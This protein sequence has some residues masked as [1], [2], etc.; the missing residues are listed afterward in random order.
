MCNAKEK[1]WPTPLDCTHCLHWGYFP[2]PGHRYRSLLSHPQRQGTKTFGSKQPAPPPHRWFLE[3]SGDMHGMIAS[4]ACLGAIRNCIPGCRATNQAEVISSIG[5][6]N[7]Q[8]GSGSGSGYYPPP[9]L[10][11]IHLHPEE[12]LYCSFRAPQAQARRPSHR[13]GS[14][15]EGQIFY[16]RVIGYSSSVV[17]YGPLTGLGRTAR[18]QRHIHNT[19]AHTGVLTRPGEG[20]SQLKLG[21]TSL[22]QVQFEKGF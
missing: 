9:H 6:N 14:T 18:G 20:C 16:S 19:S 13:W 11:V 8:L 15:V 3:E 22:V 10:A 2:W 7:K 4:T 12:Y 1:L 21:P 5:Y 17:P